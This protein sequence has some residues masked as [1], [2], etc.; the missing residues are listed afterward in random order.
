MKL[1]TILKVMQALGLNPLQEVGVMKRIKHWFCG[2]TQSLNPLQE[3]GVMKP[4]RHIQT[5]VRPVLIPFRKS[6]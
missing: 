2:N 5:C 1:D 6:G 4:I 3:V